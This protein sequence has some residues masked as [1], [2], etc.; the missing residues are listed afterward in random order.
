MEAAHVRRRESEIPK[1]RYDD[2]GACAAFGGF[3]PG[4]PVQYQ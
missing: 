1:T 2:A 4:D 3:W